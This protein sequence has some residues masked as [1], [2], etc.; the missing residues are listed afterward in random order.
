MLENFYSI[1]NTVVVV[2]RRTL[3][4]VVGHETVTLFGKARGILGDVG[5]VPVEALVALGSNLVGPVCDRCE[6]R[7]ADQGAN[8]SFRLTAEPALGQRRYDLVPFRPP[9]EQTGGQEQ[10]QDCNG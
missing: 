3:M 6:P 7:A 9:A 4:P 5:K 1:H 10:R 8:P 2:G